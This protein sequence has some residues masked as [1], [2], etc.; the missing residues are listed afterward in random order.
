VGVERHDRVEG[1]RRADEHEPVHPPWQVHGAIRRPEAA[2][3]VPHQAHPVQAEAF[4]QFAEPSPVVVP[5]GDHPGRPAPVR[6]SH[7]VNGED[8]VMLG[9]RT[10]R[11][12][13]GHGRRE[14]GV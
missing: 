12:L 7:D 11:R 13:P 14:E 1:R 3:G 4:N 9:E 8:T 6:L 5:G 10:N 2:H